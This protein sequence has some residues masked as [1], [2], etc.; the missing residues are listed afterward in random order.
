MSDDTNFYENL[1]L[2]LF[3]DQ[4]LTLLNE[5][6]ND[7]IS[8]LNLNKITSPLNLNLNQI[9]EILSEQFI[10]NFDNIPDYLRVLMSMS[11]R[12]CSLLINFFVVNVKDFS[13]TK[14]DLSDWIQIKIDSNYIFYKIKL[15]DLDLKS[16]N[17]FSSYL[18][19]L[20]KYENFQ[21]DQN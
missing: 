6:R 4:I 2:I 15:V 18:D 21:L 12:D 20:I 1:S 5:A 17:K 11:L 3:N 16:L 10:K 7:L 14:L 13:I 9:K 8:N 19:E